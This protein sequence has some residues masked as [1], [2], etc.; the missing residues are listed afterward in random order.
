MLII[1]PMKRI[2]M[3]N[4][5]IQIKKALL[6]ARLRQ[7]DIARNLRITR[8]GVSAIVRGKH[9]SL[10]VKRAIAKATRKRVEEL[11]PLEPRRVQGFAQNHKRRAA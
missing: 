10:R 5:E 7:I 2:H 8:Q 3:S 9:S 6:D 4:S 11:W 1:I